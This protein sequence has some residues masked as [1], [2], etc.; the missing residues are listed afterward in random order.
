MRRRVPGPASSDLR[1]QATKTVNL[2]TQRYGF[3][4]NI[5]RKKEHRMLAR[6]LSAAILIPAVLATEATAQYVIAP[7][8][9]FPFC[10][11]Y[12][13]NKNIPW[14]P[15][16]I[17]DSPLPAGCARSQCIRRGACISEGYYALF[18]RK[19]PNSD[20]YLFHYIYAPNGCLK[21]ICTA[22]PKRTSL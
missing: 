17:I 16:R 9:I 15:N 4:Y 1:A 22:M 12:I 18:D 3:A 13:V 21:L 6:I 10:Q 11:P 14:P 2:I 19:Y 20:I 7:H 5:F 8:G